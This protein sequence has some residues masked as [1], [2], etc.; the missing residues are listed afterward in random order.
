[1][2]KERAIFWIRMILFIGF[3][4]IVPLA[5]LV[6]RFELFKTVSKVS[7]GGWG[8]VLIIFFIVYLWK[9]VSSVRKGMKFGLPKQILDGLCGTTIPLFASYW[10]LW[11]LSGN[12]QELVQ[13][14]LVLTISE[15]I[16]IP[17]NPIPKWQHENHKEITDMTLTQIISKIN[18]KKK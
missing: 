6:W 2:S 10:I 4:L 9:L 3:S 15:T 1:M 13:F 11:W 7:I 5:F 12:I 17:I 18:S 14:L 16:A 8:L